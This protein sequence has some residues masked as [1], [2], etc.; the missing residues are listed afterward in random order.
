MNSDID[1][2]PWIGKSETE[3]GVV[4]AYPANCFSMTLDRDDPPFLEGSALPPGWHYFY[5]HELVALA[6][7]GDDGHKK[8][9]DFLPPIPFPRRMWAGSK[10]E[11][12]SPILIGEKVR[13]TVTIADIEIK[14]GKTGPLCFVTTK[15]EVFGEDGRLATL[16]ERKQV[17]RD[18]PNPSSSK[19]KPKPEPAT[20]VWSRT[21][22][23]DPVLLFRYSALTM[24][25][26]RIHYDKD[27]VRDIEGYPGLLVHGPL[28][29]TLMLDLFRRELPNAAVTSFDLRAVSPIYDTMD[30]SVHGNPNEE[31]QMCKLWAMSGEGALAMTAEVAYAL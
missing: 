15:E 12:S 22:Q 9:G 29:M 25:S 7:T 16:E 6:D 23:P 14:D 5:F 13:K 18:N 2:S 27:Y 10:M 28:T 26:H 3:Q 21:I 19:P 17:Y 1:F 4:S 8:R 30:F 24:N 11:F 31:T 20:P